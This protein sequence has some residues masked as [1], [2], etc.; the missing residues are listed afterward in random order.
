M[1]D[2]KVKKFFD[3]DDVR[4]IELSLLKS[5]I[6]AAIRFSE[7][8]WM[9]YKEKTF[10]IATILDLTYKKAYIEVLF[11][12]N[13]DVLQKGLPIVKIYSPTETTFDFNEV[14][15]NPDFDDDGLVSPNKVMERLNKV[16][17]KEVDHH[18]DVLEKEI[19]LLDDNFENYPIGNNEYFRKILIYFT[20]YL[21]SIQINLENYPDIPHFS[22]SRQLVVLRFREPFMEKIRGKFIKGDK[23]A[24]RDKSKEEIKIYDYKKEIKINETKEPFI[25]KF[26]KKLKDQFVVILDERF[27]DAAREYEDKLKILQESDIDNIEI[28]KDWDVKKPPH[29]VDLINSILKVEQG[30]QHLMLEDVSISDE[31]FNLNFKI[32]RGQTI[33]IFLENEESNQDEGNKPIKHLFQAIKGE[34]SDFSGT[35]SIFNKEVKKD[36]NITIKDV[37]FVSDRFDKKMKRMK[38]IKAITYKIRLIGKRKS[39]KELIHSALDATGLLHRKNE[40]ISNLSTLERIQFSISRA[41]IRMQSI[42]MISLPQEEINRLQCEQF[43]R[44]VQKIKQEFHV[45]LLIHGPRE[46]IS[47]CEKIITIKNKQAEIGTIEHFISKIPQA[48]EIITIDLESP[49]EET[50]REMFQISSAIFVEERKN[51]RYK[52]Y[53][54]EENPDDMIIKLMNIV[55]DYIYSFKKQKA[56]L[57]EY[58]EFTKITQQQNY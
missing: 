39:K 11:F 27:G 45:I 8:Y 4:D 49:D 50:L 42:I 40:K 44:Y 6:I 56:T 55:G 47:N 7:H 17:K 51:E 32:H 25:D 41:I 15:I 35:I 9:I 34:F 28:M 37:S 46:I 20:D 3:D 53:C 43:C 24:L 31:I 33:G 5:K 1:N 30:S 16:I 14:V 48:G 10:G 38:I 21:V 58:S 2:S 29:V 26:L 57:E 52:I 12:T 22:E 13:I 23:T 18:L 36:E 54:L 19:R